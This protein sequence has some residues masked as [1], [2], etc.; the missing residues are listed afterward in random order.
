MLPFLLCG[1][2]QSQTTWDKYFIFR[3]VDFQLKGQVHF[4]H[5]YCHRHCC[6]VLQCYLIWWKWLCIIFDRITLNVYILFYILR[7]S[8]WKLLIKYIYKDVFWLLVSK[9]VSIRIL[10][11]F[12]PIVCNQ[13]GT[14]LATAENIQHLNISSY[15]ESFSVQ[16]IM[17]VLCL[18]YWLINSV[19][20]AN[21]R[22]CNLNQKQKSSVVF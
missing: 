2:R 1:K 19:Y 10:L 4:W 16:L 18:F 20:W 12:S 14:A 21:Q 11:W 7:Q 13:S 9:Q 22:N 15:Q 5:L 8:M 3:M 17:A 6:E